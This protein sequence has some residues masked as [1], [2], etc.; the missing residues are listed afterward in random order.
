MYNLNSITGN[1]LRGRSIQARNSSLERT[2][3]AINLAASF[4]GVKMT[5]DIFITSYAMDRVFLAMV[6]ETVEAK[7]AGSFQTYNIIEKGE[8]KLPKG[9]RLTS[10]SWSGV[11]PGSSRKGNG[12]IKSMFWESP[13][14]IVKRISNW[15]TNG[16]LL[17]LLITQTSVNLDCYVQEFQYK[18]TGG[19]G[20]V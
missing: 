20:D 19:A 1:V 18:Y 16:E 11:F 3:D 13:K 10:V 8:V 15:K 4:F 17:N 5:A 6:P 14:A 12:F 7:E 2:M 9:E